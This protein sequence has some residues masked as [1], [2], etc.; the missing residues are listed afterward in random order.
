MAKPNISAERLRQLLD[1][2]RT[3]GLFMWRED[4][5]QVVKAGDPAGYSCNGYTYIH[6]EGRAYPAHN[7]A[8]LHV[9]GQWPAF[10]VDH[11][12]GVRH[13]NHWL[14]LRDVTH[15]TNAENRVRANANNS[16]GML[17]VTFCRGRYQARIRVDGK[18]QFLGSFDTPE[19]AHGVYLAAKRELHKGCTL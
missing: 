2:D 9:T 12:N 19:K 4:R 18:L 13:A 10:E 7:L 1:Y 8:W 5:A 3:S 17:G 11:R 6:V 16:T 14:N 15:Q